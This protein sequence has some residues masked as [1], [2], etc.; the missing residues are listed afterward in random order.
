MGSWNGMPSVYTI[1]NSTTLESN[2]SVA[3]MCCV[4]LTVC[5]WVHG[6]VLESRR[7][8]Q[9]LAVSGARHAPDARMEHKPVVRPVRASASSASA[10]APRRKCRER[11][12]AETRVEQSLSEIAVR[13]CRQAPAFH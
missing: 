3:R 6:R 7:C 10:L 4:V 13:C 2:M 9:T 1:L 12:E 11:D 8:G 5:G